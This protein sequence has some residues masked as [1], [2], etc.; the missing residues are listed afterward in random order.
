MFLVDADPHG[1]EIISTFV[2]G[3][4]ALS[5]DSSNLAIGIRRATWLGL[6]P[7]SIGAR[8][9]T[10]DQM[11]MLN[12]RDRRKILAMLKREWFPEEWK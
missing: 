7:T 3:S 9:E 1:I 10:R 11:L 5:H 12:A 2:L 8:P 4:S 6:R